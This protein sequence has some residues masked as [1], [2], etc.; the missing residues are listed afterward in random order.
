[1]MA[2]NAAK[3]PPARRVATEQAAAAG[4]QERQHGE[5]QTSVDAKQP[6]S[7]A[8]RGRSGSPQLRRSVPKGAPERRTSPS[9]RPAQSPA[10]PAHGS[11]APQ[12]DQQKR[13]SP[14]A[15]PSSG[16]KPAALRPQH[17]L[18]SGSKSESQLQPPKAKAQGTA[19]P[20]RGDASRGQPGTA[21]SADASALRESRMQLEQLKKT[22]EKEKKQDD[23]RRVK[24]FREAKKKIAKEMKAAQQDVKKSEREEGKMAGKLAKTQS[25]LDRV[26][27]TKAKQMHAC[28]ELLG[29]HRNVVC[30][31]GSA[32][33]EQAERVGKARGRLAH[34]EFMAKLLEEQASGQTV[35]ALADH[36]GAATEC[37]GK[38]L[39]APEVKAL[40]SLP[41]EATTEAP[42]DGVKV[43][44]GRVSSI[45]SR[46][47][48]ADPAANLKAP[49]ME[50]VVDLKPTAPAGDEPALGMG[51]ERTSDPRLPREMSYDAGA[52]MQTPTRVSSAT[53][54]STKD[55]PGMP[56]WVAPAG[57]GCS[58][59]A[60]M[61]TS[62]TTPEVQIAST[63]SLGQRSESPTMKRSAT[64]AT[65]S[66]S[67]T[68]AFSPPSRSPGASPATSPASRL[69]ASAQLQGS[70]SMSA[71]PAQRPTTPA[72]MRS[73]L[74]GVTLPPG[75]AAAAILPTAAWKQTSSMHSP[76]PGDSTYPGSP[77]DSPAYASNV[78]LGLGHSFPVPVR[79]EASASAPQHPTPSWASSCGVGADVGVTRSTRIHPS[80]FFK[81]AT[82]RTASGAS[83]SPAGGSIGGFWPT[84]SPLMTTSG[85][86]VARASRPELPTAG[87]ALHGRRSEDMSGQ[88][89][90]EP[91]I[92]LPREPMMPRMPVMQQRPVHSVH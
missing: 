18:S 49:V 63:T 72:A 24:D 50:A 59:T 36:V 26:E 28:D 64:G 47:E 8:G 38:A 22:Q 25:Q 52:S 82:L 54:A 92:E 16:P 2:T 79:V 30:Q 66:D 9:N 73:S 4:S 86:A 10:P 15:P 61:P 46:A 74:S 20:M 31:L 40:T 7:T 71:F 70:A 91:I 81:A 67:R 33:H 83:L 17:R 35:P 78:V 12:M 23:Q 6:S 65:V 21:G 13:A 29:K 56:I 32:L 89:P 42:E 43:L 76:L 80:T 85:A 34:A 77:T 68:T 84:A 57:E 88:L 44:L 53:T 37:E 41:S 75:V 90:S 45:R 62:P 60:S 58:T 51:G 14:K 39:P 55:V 5:K 3:A 11:Q 19:S 27:A 1:M 87:G 69:T 48:E